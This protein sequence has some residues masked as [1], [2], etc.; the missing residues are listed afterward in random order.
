MK[1]IPRKEKSQNLLLRTEAEHLHT[2][3][4]SLCGEE[5]AV[6]RASTQAQLHSLLESHVDSTLLIDLALYNDDVDHPV[7]ARILQQ[8]SQQ[9]IVIIT[10]ENDE[11]RLYPLLTQGV[12]GFCSPDCSTEL[13]LRMAQTVAQGEL[14]I[15]RKMLSYSIGR[16]QLEGLGDK[17]VSEEG[18]ANSVSDL[19]ELTRREI[20]IARHIA[21]GKSDKTVA[22]ELKISSNT[23]KN[24]LRNIFKKLDVSDRLQLALRCHGIDGGGI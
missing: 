8:G 20:E 9:K 2:R 22:I 14:W 23:V 5:R 3:L 10:S 7:I 18:L 13:L 17:G 16:Q 21:Q 1:K 12:R 24:H 15:S 4:S 6:W 19:S 11:A